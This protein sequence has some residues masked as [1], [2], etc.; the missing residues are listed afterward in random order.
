MRA[1]RIKT[2]LPKCYTLLLSLK[3]NNFLY[4]K[5]SVSYSDLCRNI[6]Y[7]LFVFI[8]D[9]LLNNCFSNHHDG[10]MLHFSKMT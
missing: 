6:V 7:I 10:I 9:I 4:L 1:H 8:Y 2:Q 3:K 5:I